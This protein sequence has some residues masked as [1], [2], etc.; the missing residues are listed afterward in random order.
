[1]RKSKKRASTGEI[2]TVEKKV[3]NIGSDPS[4]GHDTDSDSN[5]ED[6]EG[7]RAKRSSLG[8]V[9]SAGKKSGK[10][11]LGKKELNDGQT[12]E[13][14]SKRKLGVFN[15]RFVN[16]MQV[17]PISSEKKLLPM[18]DLQILCSN[19]TLRTDRNLAPPFVVQ[20][21]LVEL[22]LLKWPRRWDSKDGQ[23]SFEDHESGRSVERRERALKDYP[24]GK[25]I[26]EELTIHHYNDTREQK[27]LEMI[28]ATLSSCVG[29][30]GQLQP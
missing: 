22:I 26:P 24:D 3:E 8:S 20:K 21:C 29:H 4:D 19:V 28:H 16:H 11:R 27:A 23:P 10:R 2:K 7:R 6:R 5:V 25:D 1:M 15:D 12:V 30:A 18:V 17:F 13:K 9:G 14:R